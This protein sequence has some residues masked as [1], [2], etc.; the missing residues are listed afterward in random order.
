M[1]R[2]VNLFWP[3]VLIAA[4]ALWILIELGRVPFE[5]LWALAILWPFLLIGAG[6]SLLLRPYW[7]YANAVMS[8]LVVGGLFIAVV[9]A[10]QFG[11]NH[12][13]DRIFDGGVFFGGPSARGSG[14]VISQ[15]RTIRD[16][17]S[18]H[19]AYPAH[20]VIQQGAAEGLTIKAEDNVVAA[21]DTRVVNHALEIDTLHDHRVIVVPTKPVDITIT[22]KDLS[23]LDFNSAGDVVVQGLRS[24]DFKAVL[25]GAGSIKLPGFP[26][27]IAGCRI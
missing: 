15:S 14:N 19:I 4:G 7:R 9:F 24:D 3:L 5:N 11:W 23:E 16:I 27:E 22:V 8:L 10:A 6:L 13:P 20:I 21:I 12:V 2:R 1:E 25:N 18:I 26:I 17:S